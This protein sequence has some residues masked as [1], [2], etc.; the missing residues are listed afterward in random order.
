MGITS[1]GDDIDAICIAPR[2]VDN[3]DFFK[4]LSAMLVKHSYV[5]SARPIEGARV[6]LIDLVMK[7]IPIDLLFCRLNRRTVP[8]A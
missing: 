1:E 2:H 4:V 5:D 3:D 6:P 7:G 8:T